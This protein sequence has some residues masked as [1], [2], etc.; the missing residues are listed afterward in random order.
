MNVAQGYLNSYCCWDR[1]HQ[2]YRLKRVQG[3]T[4]LYFIVSHKRTCSKN[5]R[6]QHISP[7]IMDPNFVKSIFYTCLLKFKISSWPQ[8]IL[9]VFL[10]LKVE[11]LFCVKT[12]YPCSQEWQHPIKFEHACLE[13]VKYTNA[14]F[15]H[16]EC[17]K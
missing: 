3:R 2:F 14:S 17:L 5:E 13:S 15:V 6:K 11:K 10:Y 12:L 8:E 1:V 16:R 4:L 7:N 9:F